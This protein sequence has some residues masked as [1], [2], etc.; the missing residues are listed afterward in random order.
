MIGGSPIFE[1]YIVLLVVV[2]FAYWYSVQRHRIDTD[3][4]LAEQ[5]VTETQPVPADV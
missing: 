2:G 5:P 3:Q 4:Q 1:V